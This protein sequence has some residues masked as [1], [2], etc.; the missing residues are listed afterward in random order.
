MGSVI[1][2]CLNAVYH[3]PHMKK[4]HGHTPHGIA[5]QHYR[6]I[7]PMAEAFLLVNIF[8]CQIDSSCKACLSVNDTDLS[9]ISVILDNI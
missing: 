6:R 9:V 3:I 2:R 4:H 5:F 8:I 7:L 1:N